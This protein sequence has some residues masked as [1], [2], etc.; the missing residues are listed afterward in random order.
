MQTLMIE[1]KMQS[2]G[3]MEHS[4]TRAAPKSDCGC[5]RT[6]LPRSVLVSLAMIAFM[7]AIAGNA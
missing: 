3:S 4:K 1:A 6:A 5:G 2:D 7:L